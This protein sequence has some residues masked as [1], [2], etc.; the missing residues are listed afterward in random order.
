MTSASLA[1]LAD[2]LRTGSRT[3][4]DLVDHA[5]SP[6]DLGATEWLLPGARADADASAARRADGN[7]LGD[8]D[9]IPF[10]VKSNI[11]VAGVP[12]TSGTA[13]HVPTARR[14]ATVIQRLRTAGFIPVRTATMAELAIGSV[15]DNP[16][17]GTCRNPRNPALSAGG[18]SGGSAALVAAGLVPFALG[19]DTMGSVRIPAAY[20]GICAYKPSRGVIDTEGLTALYPPLDTVGVLAS[21]I[22]G[23]IAVASVVAD[24]N[25]IQHQE[26]SNVTVGIPALADLADDDGHR[27]LEVAV[28]AL[29]SLGV[30]VISV[31]MDV[32]PAVV[33]RRGL[34]LCEV[35]TYRRFA[36]ATDGDDPGL[37][38]SVRGLLRFGAAAPAD[39]VRAA[40]EALSTAGDSIEA[41]FGS[42]DFMVL[43][44]TPEG[45]PPVGHEPPHAGDLTAWANVAGVPAVAFPAGPDTAAG[46]PR[47]VQLVGR[48]GADA[49]VLALAATVAARTVSEVRA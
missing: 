13:L 26:H 22:N 11:D 24:V 34:L 30:T 39:K 31:P 10:A 44:T 47:G 42:V 40:E 1:E 19:S 48:R 17:T 23:L 2:S 4:V 38:E 41:A 36:E 12:T 14:D 27:A 15:T 49:A 37:S 3:A 21:D 43:P 6:D 7:P 18:S 5:L 28:A 35:D 29:R 8:F 46:M 9:G 25:P 20:C 32:D 45:P 33:R 16:H